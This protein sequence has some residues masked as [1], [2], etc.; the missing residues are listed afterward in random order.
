MRTVLFPVMDAAIYADTSLPRQNTGADQILEIGHYNADGSNS[1]I[2][3]LIQFDISSISASLVSGTLPLNAQYDLT[4][5]VAEAQKLINGQTLQYQL[6]SQSWVE[7]DGFF[8]EQITGSVLGATWFQANSSSLWIFYSASTSGALPGGTTQSIGPLSNSFANPI[9]DVTTNITSFVNLWL[10]GTFPNFGM[11]VQFPVADE[12][13]SANQGNVKFF[14]RQT[15]TIYQPT[16]TIKW[17]DQLISTGSLTASPQIDLFVQPTGV[18]PTY[19]Q[20]EIVRVNLAVR[21]RNPL[22]TFSTVFSNYAAG[23]YYLPSSSYYSIKDEAAGTILIPFDSY[24]L[25]SCS[26]SG[27]YFNFTVTPNFF[28]L[29]T[30]RVLVRVDHDGISEVFDTNQLFTVSL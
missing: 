18:K 27:A 26:P 20:N 3:S 6:V 28:P 10:S 24:S 25:V 22:K 9:A 7:G 1:A 15:H 19:K 17:N 11:L 14:S 29:R 5:Y 8:W 23:Q 13:N 4:L 2:R 30:Y 12:V 16:L 21:P